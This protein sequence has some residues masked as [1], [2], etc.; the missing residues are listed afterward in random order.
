MRKQLLTGSALLW[1]T[2]TWSQ[3]KP[4]AG[5]SEAGAK[6]EFAVEEKFDSYLQAGNIDSSMKILSSHPHHVGSPG[7]KA[8]ADYIYQRFKSWGYDV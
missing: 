2:L 7:G 6:Q 5:F 1:A 3:T 8:D 4:L